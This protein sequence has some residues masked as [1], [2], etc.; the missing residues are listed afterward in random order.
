MSDEYSGGLPLIRRRWDGRLREFVHPADGSEASERPV[1]GHGDPR[2]L[3]T[4]RTGQLIP[5]RVRLTDARAPM[6]VPL[7]KASCD[8]SGACCGLYHH[9]PATTEDRDAVIEAFGDDWDGAVPL[10]DAFHPAFEGRENP[11]NIVAVDG[12]CAFHMEDGRCRIHAKAGANAKPQSCLSYP[13]HLVACGSEWHASLRTEC[14]CVARSAIEGEP[15]GADPEVW[16]RLR[17]TLP[18]I[19]AVPRQVAIDERSIAREVYVEWMRALVAA[20]KTTFD[21]IAALEDGRRALFE[22][23]GAEVEPLGFPSATWLTPVA[24]LLTAE[25]DEASRTFHP[26]SPYR[27]SIAWGAEV[28]ASLTG[29]VTP[30]WSRGRAS[31]WGRRTASTL[32]LVLHGHALLELPLLGEALDDLLY[33][34]QLARTSEGVS[35]AIDADPRLESLTTWLFLY[36][37]VLR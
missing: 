4:P 34:V 17:S 24:A 33:L 30:T 7:L 3:R 31:D 19:W 14:A 15:L 11:L 27:R 36:R 6:V 2:G 21:P 18:R 23:I 20:L 26:R 37:N 12:S 8:G 9:V 35:P 10:A 22:T 32:S 29:P 25:A 16:V 5:R 1:G 28:A 13:A